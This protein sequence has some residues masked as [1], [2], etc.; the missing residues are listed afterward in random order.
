MLEGA[1]WILFLE[2]DY[3]PLVVIINLSKSTKKKLR[4][5]RENVKRKDNFVLKY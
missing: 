5:K 2:M 4:E 1:R 3:Q